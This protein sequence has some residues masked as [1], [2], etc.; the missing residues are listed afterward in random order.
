M[1]KTNNTGVRLTGPQRDKLERLAESL[2]TSRNRIFGLLIDAAEV[3]SM[4]ALSVGVQKS[5]LGVHTTKA[6][7]SALR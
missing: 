6:A 5:G 2:N 1:K 3:Q 4:P 7:K